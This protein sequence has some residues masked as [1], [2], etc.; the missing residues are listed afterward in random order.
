[1]QDGSVDLVFVCDP[2]HHIE[3]RGRYAGR[4]LKVL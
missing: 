3:D 2:W 1:L 4:L